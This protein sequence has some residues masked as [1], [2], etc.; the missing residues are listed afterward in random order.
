[1]EGDTSAISLLTNRARKFARRGPLSVRDFRWLWAGQTISLL[2]DQFYLVALPWLV[3]QLTGSSLA[4]G[5]VLMASTVP[6]IVFLLIGGAATDWLSPHKLMIASNALRSLVCATLTVL[7]LF[8]AI[9]LWQLVILAVAF[10]TLD[11][12]FSPAIK[13]FIPSVL[14]ADDL[15]VGNSLLQST[16]M[17]TRFVGPA[18]GGLVVAAAGVGSAL[19]ADTI[20]FVV[21]TVCL[22][23]MTTRKTDN[24]SALRNRKSSGSLLTSIRDGLL[25]TLKQPSLRS[26]I[27]VVSVIEFAF[28]GPLSVGLA[29]LANS[30]F[31]GGSKG[32]GVMLSTLGGGFLLG[33]LL[34]GALKTTRLGLAIFVSSFVLGGSLTLLGFA[35][36]L[37]SACALLLVIATFGGYIQVLNT[38]W[39]QTRSDPTMR[40]RVMSVA[41]VCGFGLTPLSYLVSGALEKVSLTLVFVVNGALLLVAAVL[42]FSKVRQIDIVSAS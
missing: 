42:F 38:V 11:A 28:A 5:L 41:M 27:I 9:S 33:T 29:S 3:L 32:L 36:N 37:V 21:V 30:R 22:L 19:G 14:G 26:L 35:P 24:S 6:R 1:M 8:K 39:Y 17:I 15:M 12:F 34:A 4:L 2:G 23:M 25:Y 40:G 31:T 10:G 20:S 13:A 16:D 7:V 18:I